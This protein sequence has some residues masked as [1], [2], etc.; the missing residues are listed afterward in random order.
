MYHAGTHDADRREEV[1]HLTGVVE[2]GDFV[3]QTDGLER[4]EAVDL[5][6]AVAWADDHTEPQRENPRVPGGDGLRA[7][8]AAGEL[9]G[10]HALQAEGDGPIDEVA[11]DADER[12]GDGGHGVLL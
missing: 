1:D 6:G 2:H 5:V 10:G 9:G 8:A 11:P 12:A 7:A 4:V 3:V